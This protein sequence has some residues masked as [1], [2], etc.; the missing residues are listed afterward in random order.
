VFFDIV[1]GIEI[2][3][4]PVSPRVRRK[5]FQRDGWHCHYCDVKLYER[6]GPTVDHKVPKARGGKNTI[7]NLVACC[8]WCNCAKGDMPYALF[9]VL[10]E[11]VGHFS[12]VRKT[13]EKVSALYHAQMRN[14]ER[15]QWNAVLCGAG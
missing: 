3:A 1:L 11:E 13:V 2:M 6:E 4:G 9:V 15:P 7:D 14:P 5:V 12:T 8:R 10:L